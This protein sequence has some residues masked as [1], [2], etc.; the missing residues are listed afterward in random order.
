MQIDTMHAHDGSG[1][2]VGTDNHPGNSAYTQNIGQVFTVTAPDTRLRRF[3]FRIHDGLISR[4]TGA[5]DAFNINAY[6]MKWDDQHAVGDPLWETEVQLHL[7]TLHRV[8]YTDLE[9]FPE[10]VL[11]D[12]SQYVVFLSMIGVQNEMWRV[13]AVGGYV[14]G[15]TYDGGFQVKRGHMT[16]A[17]LTSNPWEGSYDKQFDLACRIEFATLPQRIGS[18]PHGPYVIHQPRSI[19][20]LGLINRRWRKLPNIPR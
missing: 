20:V 2:F 15:G 12:G 18:L 8:T 19:D 4:G 14:P 13:I 5:D 10:Q 7:D 9:L 11:R 3:V 16:M 1:A 6:L 17:Q